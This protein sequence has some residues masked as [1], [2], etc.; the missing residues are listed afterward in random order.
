MREPLFS[1]GSGRCAGVQALRPSPHHTPS[2]KVEKAHGITGPGQVGGGSR[3][4][5]QVAFGIP[6]LWQQ[7]VPSVR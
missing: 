4:C 6:S 3:A 7:L 5:G 2:R 1:G